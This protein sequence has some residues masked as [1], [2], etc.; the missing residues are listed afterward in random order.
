MRS[1]GVDV[2]YCE[3]KL[4]QPPELNEKVAGPRGCLRPSIRCQGG[5]GARPLC[6]CCAVQRLTGRLRGIPCPSMC[7]TIVSWV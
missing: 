6:L 2:V 5:C 4:D 3:C 7:L 1:C